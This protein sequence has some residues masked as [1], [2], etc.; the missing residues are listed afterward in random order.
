[1]GIEVI[2]EKTEK[3]RRGAG[4]GKGVKTWDF[5]ALGKPDLKIGNGS[6]NKKKNSNKNKLRRGRRVV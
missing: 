2:I 1:V 5:Q 3:K 6:V 4:V